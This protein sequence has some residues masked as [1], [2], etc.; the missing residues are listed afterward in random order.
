MTE[1]KI[2]GRHAVNVQLAVFSPRRHSLGRRTVWLCLLC[3][4]VCV[5]R[6]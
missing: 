4:L 1:R 3:V 2:A 5:C 6:L